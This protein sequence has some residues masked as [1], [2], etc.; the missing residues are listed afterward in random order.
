MNSIL[1]VDNNPKDLYNVSL[2][3][4]NHGFSVVSATNRKDAMAVLGQKKVDLAVLD[5]RLID[6]TDKFDITG[7]EIAGTSDRLIP[8]I[9]VSQYES[10]DAAA[11]GLKIDVEGYPSIIDFIGKADISTKLIPAVQRAMK[12]KKTWQAMVQ[13]SVTGQLNKDY[14]DARFAAHLHYFVSLA[15]SILFALPILYGAF[16]LHSKAEDKISMLFVVGGIL[17]AEVTHHLFNRNLE[18]LYQRVSKFHSELLQTNRFE[19]LLEGSYEIADEDERERFKARLFETA[20][21]KWL[22]RDEPTPYLD[23]LPPKPRDSQ[24][25]IPPGQFRE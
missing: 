7:L 3:I 2:V 16:V 23:D 1:V 25:V 21:A 15:L 14:K 18:F 20:A 17:V 9:I 12:I 6:D 10:P 22:R 8:K 4:R 13:S 5:L 24:S 19:R 11:Q